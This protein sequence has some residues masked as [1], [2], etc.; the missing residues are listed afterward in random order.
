MHQS[1]TKQYFCKSRPSTSRLNIKH[2][3]ALTTQSGSS[4]HT[5]IILF[6]KLYLN[7]STAAHCFSLLISRILRTDISSSVYCT[8]NCGR[9]EGGW[10]KKSLFISKSRGALLV[11]VI[12]TKQQK[13]F[14]AHITKK[15]TT[16]SKNFA[17]IFTNIKSAN[18]YVEI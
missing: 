8:R 5:P 16:I 10:L 13:E 11:T 17:R 4:F 6:G 3:E 14:Y 9:G 12:C 2:V 1:H 15:L 18:K 7:A